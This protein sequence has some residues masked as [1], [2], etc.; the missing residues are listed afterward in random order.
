[1]KV[2]AS[3]PPVP[4]QEFSGVSLQSIEM[5][6][7]RDDHQSGRG[8]LRDRPF[9][10]QP[11]RRFFGEQSDSRVN[12]NRDGIPDRHILAP[13]SQQQCRAKQP[14]PCRRLLPEG[15]LQAIQRAGHEKHLDRVESHLRRQDYYGRREAQN[16]R[17]HQPGLPVECIRYP[18]VNDIRQQSSRDHGREPE[19]QL[20]ASEISHVMQKKVRQRAM[21]VNQHRPVHR[22]QAGLQGSEHDHGFIAIEIKARGPQDA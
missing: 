8:Q 1:M 22:A 10:L 17:G 21:R 9:H 18:P 16:T 5:S 19:I 3:Q 13:Q 20:G 6:E 2:G 15:P 12:A 4:R 7:V 14:H 11:A